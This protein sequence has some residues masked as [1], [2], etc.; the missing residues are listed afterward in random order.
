MENEL[1]IDKMKRCHFVIIG[2]SIVFLLIIS[3]GI[4]IYYN[5]S[6]V[7]RNKS[8]RIINN[9]FYRNGN[10]VLV[11]N[12]DIEKYDHWLEVYLRLEPQDTVNKIIEFNA[13]TQLHIIQGIYDNVH[14]H[15]QT[16]S[17][18]CFLNKCDDIIFVSDNAVQDGE[19]LIIISIED[20]NNVFNTTDYKVSL[21]VS[22]AIRNQTLF[23]LILTIILMFIV[24]IAFIVYCSITIY[25]H[26]WTV[27]TGLNTLLLFSV[28]LFTNPIISLSFYKN[29]TW[30]DYLDNVLMEFYIFIVFIWIFFQVDHLR[31]LAIKEKYPILQWGLRSI[32]FI[33]YL[34]ALLI[35]FFSN[36]VHQYS[37]LVAT[38]TPLINNFKS[39]RDLLQLV[40]IFWILLNEFFSFTEVMNPINRK[41]LIFLTSFTSIII[42]VCLLQLFL[43]TNTHNKGPIPICLMKLVNTFVVLI[44]CVCFHQIE[45]S[46][47]RSG[48]NS[49]EMINVSEYEDFDSSSDDLD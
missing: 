36:L 14:L 16:Y 10:Y 13:Q 18:R 47:S 25:T 6:L 40:L 26:Q 9:S 20:I 5:K 42:S 38:T 28:I 12:L 43:Q 41:R 23:S 30:M 11:E 32:L 46:K 24:F 22:T 21:S 35:Y 27:Y 45:L 4:S 33:L 15:N 1:V 48:F 3:I 7:V 37:P 31:F 29:Y 49:R 34:F 39:I 8:P 17:T 2:N 44:M 19:Y